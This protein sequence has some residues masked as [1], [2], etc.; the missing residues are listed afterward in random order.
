MLAQSVLKRLGLL[1]AASLALALLVAGMA[2]AETNTFVATDDAWVKNS[3]P[4]KNYGAAA[5]LLTC[6][7]GRTCV[8]PGDPASVIRRSFVEF[9]PRGMSGSINKATLR[10]QV[11]NPSVGGPALRH[12]PN[13]SWSEGNLTYANQPA[14]DATQLGSSGATTNRQIV[15]Y[16]VTRAVKAEGLNRDYSFRFAQTNSDL[17][18]FASK[19]AAGNYMK[20]RLVIE[21]TPPPP[22]DAD[23]DGVP[24]SSDNCPNAPNPG[25]ADA[26]GDG[27]GDAC[28]A[29]D[30][31]YVNVKDHGA[32]GNGSSNDTRGFE[33][34]MDAAGAGE[35]VLVPEGTNATYRIDSVNVPSNTTIHVENGATLKKFGND[36]GP[37]FTVQGTQNQSFARDVHIQG[38]GGRFL[39]DLNDAGQDTGAIRYRSVI[40]FSLKNMICKQNWDNRSQGPPSS[41]KPCISALPM[42]DTKLNGE[43]EHPINGT[44]ENVHSTQSPY[45]WGLVQLSGGKDLSF[46]NISSQGGST[47]RLES[48]EN[49]WTPMANITADGVTCTDGHNPVHVNPHNGTHG[50]F[51][52]KNVVADSCEQAIR[53]GNDANLTGSFANDSTIDGVR[54]IPGSRAQLRDPGDRGYV[55]A[56]II[57][58]SKR[59]T[60]T[61]S[62]LGYGVTLSNMDCGG[63]PRD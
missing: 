5:S 42:D 33:A 36:N 13:D 23:R 16:D 27:I 25:Q 12:V 53:L 14:V 32:S 51:R 26:D 52:I 31:R 8:N 30:V 56:W 49:N 38:V 18:A 46:N 50:T 3:A 2:Q 20:P 58:D 10:V 57:G 62:P 43:F 28:D 59:C 45:G 55:G 24:D 47:L 17:S 37:L 9:K 35:V 63:T 7:G 11:T 39:M 19:E 22:P 60:Q 44:F 61:D 40:G 48:F 15:A 21:T 54:V 41:R 1:L 29:P 4:N 6:S 34:A